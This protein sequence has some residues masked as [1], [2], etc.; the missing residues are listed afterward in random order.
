MSTDT[1]PAAELR[2]QQGNGDKRRSDGRRSGWSRR[3]TQVVIIIGLLLLVMIA[4]IIFIVPPLLE[5]NPDISKLPPEVSLTLW[6]VIGT[7]VLL[8]MVMA[9]ALT[10]Y[11]VNGK[12]STT[13]ALGLPEGSISAILALLLLLIFSITSLYLYNQVRAGEGTGFVSSGMTEAMISQLPDGRVLS[14]NAENPT[15]DPAARTYTATVAAAH[16]ESIEIAR[17]M[18]LIVGTLLSALAGFYFG[19]RATQAGAKKAASTG[20]TGQPKAGGKRLSTVPTG[21]PNPDGG[22]PPDGQQDDGK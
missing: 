21:Q 6:L 5:Q 17:N 14:V 1:D 4:G 13:G 11:F 15:A 10:A 22:Q 19:Q 16:P 7:A 20:S 12:A 9:L 8:L 3:R 18:L 2:A